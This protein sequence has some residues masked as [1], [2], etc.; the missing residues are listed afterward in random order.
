MS[1][2]SECRCSGSFS[3]ERGLDPLRRAYSS[4]SL[5]SDRPWWDSPCPRRRRDGLWTPI[6]RR[7]E[8][9]SESQDSPKDDILPTYHMGIIEFS[10]QEI[11]KRSSVNLHFSLLC[12]VGLKC[13]K[14]KILRLFSFNSLNFHAIEASGV[15]FWFVVYIQFSN[16]WC[17]FFFFWSTIQKTLKDSRL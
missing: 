6:S 16:Q 7:R 15:S 17:F 2:C 12:L 13:A 8:H 14:H 9:S 10:N 3:S 5:L 11:K 4:A 1:S